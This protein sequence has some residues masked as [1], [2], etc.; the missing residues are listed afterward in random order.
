ML[1]RYLPLEI[2]QWYSLIEF[3]YCEESSYRDWWKYIKSMFASTYFIHHSLDVS[4]SNPAF[5]SL[6]KVIVHRIFRIKNIVW[7]S[8][9][10]IRRLSLVQLRVWLKR[11]IELM[12]SIYTCDRSK[13]TVILKHEFVFL[14]HFRKLGHSLSFFDDSTYW[15]KQ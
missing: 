13:S 4:S 12:Y 14:L 11:E 5:T 1:F 10:F 3:D 9:L 7:L 2:R 8:H 6:S 15:W